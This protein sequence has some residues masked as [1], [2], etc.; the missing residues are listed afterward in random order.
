ME[1]FP[2]E[3][4]RLIIRHIADKRTLAVI[5][6]CGSRYRALAESILYHSLRASKRHLPRHAHHYSSYPHLA[7]HL[8]V[9]RVLDEERGTQTVES[10]AADSVGTILELA[11][12]LEEAYFPSSTNGAHGHIFDRARCFNLRILRCHFRDSEREIC[13]FVA[14]CLSLEDLELTASFGEREDGRTMSEDEEAKRLLPLENHHHLRRLCLPAKHMMQIREGMWLRRY[15]D[16]SN[17]VFGYPQMVHLSKITG[18]MLQMLDVENLPED[19]EFL[20]A[21]ADMLPNLRYLA[22]PWVFTVRLSLRDASFLPSRSN[23][24]FRIPCMS[25]FSA[26]RTTARSSTCSPSSRTSRRSY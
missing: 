3:I 21:L 5:A 26:T 13:R 20:Y 24:P 25:Q 8:R 4:T 12:H 19:P 1:A 15:T 7:V 10:T 18:N 14:Q 9:L 11:A 23:Y 17:K 22:T 2:T 6:R 16:K